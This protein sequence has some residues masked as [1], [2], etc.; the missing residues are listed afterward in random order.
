MPHSISV[1]EQNISKIIQL[2][3]GI[4]RLFL[5]TV[6]LKCL[7]QKE[8]FFN[9]HHLLKDVD[10]FLVELFCSSNVFLFF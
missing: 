2:V 3:I 7:W 5:S 6:E 8:T 1:V 9:K 4:Q 10:T